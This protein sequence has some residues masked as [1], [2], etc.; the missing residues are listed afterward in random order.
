MIL[1]W[2]PHDDLCG[3]LVS[4]VTVFPEL[5][6]IFLSKK[7][8]S[9]LLGGYYSN[10]FPLNILLRFD[11]AT[12]RKLV[13]HM[14]LTQ[15][16][17]DVWIAI[18]GTPPPL[19]YDEVDILTFIASKEDIWVAEQLLQVFPN[20]PLEKMSQL[21]AFFPIPFLQWLSTKLDSVKMFRAH[22]DKHPPSNLG[23][24]LDN[25]GTTVDDVMRILTGYND[26]NDLAYARA[27]FSAMDMTPENRFT[28][29][30]RCLD[31]QRLGPISLL[32]GLPDPTWLESERAYEIIAHRL[33][34]LVFR[35]YFWLGFL[36]PVDI[37]RVQKVA[38]ECSYSNTLTWINR[39]YPLIRSA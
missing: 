16:K 39:H 10:E 6:P 27:L 37:G 23:W 1:A 13:D 22:L 24:V 5:T 17:L 21:R 3:A 31:R 36:K 7:L 20:L 14:P 12:R 18:G 29:L 8:Q 26:H 28:M 38:V 11:K 30:D 32:R 35:G 25:T 2:L 19:E 34:A 15:W 9:R 33:N 4:I